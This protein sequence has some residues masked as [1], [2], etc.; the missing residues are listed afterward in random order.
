MQKDIEEAN[1][2]K[3]VEDGILL[4]MQDVIDKKIEVR[5]H[6]S[7]RLHAKIYIFLPENFNEHSTGTVITG[8]SNLTD[9]GLGTY[10]EKCNYEFNVE[11]RGYDDVK[12]AVD[13]FDKLWKDSSEILT[14]DFNRVKDITH[15]D[16]LFTSYEIYLKF[17]IEYFGKNIDYDPE[18]IGDVPSNF[19]KLSY[20][21]DAVNQGFN[22]LMDH[23]GFFLA[24]VVGIGKTVVAAMLAKKFII[25]NGTS[26]TKILVVYPPALE[27]NWKR[28]FRLFNIDRY[29]KFISN[30]SLE[31]IING[32][33]LN[34][35]TKEDYDLVLIDEA[36]KF[37][38]HRSQMFQ[39]LQ[40]VCKSG[41]RNNGLIA[42]NNKKIVLIS[43]TP[44]N[45]RPEDIYYQL[46][47]FQNSR[48]STLP[49]T[50]LQTFFGKI[51]NKYREIKK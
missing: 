42:G 35:W 50:N 11:L 6:N 51:I 32:D 36:H 49:A 3:K 5:A 18:T 43:A 44:L 40:L 47:L 16:R 22:M 19:K 13:E 15:I 29:A 12:F 21:V 38:N 8:S 28:T 17:L 1:Y 24:D 27:K 48:K 2:S 26:N 9:A 31:K 20:Q 33:D 30:G 46:L 37:R 41:R 25:T 39:N 10:D 34:Y 45:N 7:K 4:F 23:N 14:E